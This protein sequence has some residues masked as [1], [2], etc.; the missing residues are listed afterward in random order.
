MEENLGKVFGHYV[1]RWGALPMQ[2]LVIDEL[3]L[4]D[5]QYVHVGLPH[6]QVVPVSFYGLLPPGDSS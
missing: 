2:I 5:A 1:T 3:A 4:R 6:H